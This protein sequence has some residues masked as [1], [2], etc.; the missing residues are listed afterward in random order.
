MDMYPNFYMLYAYLTEC[1]TYEHVRHKP[2]TGRGRTFVA[3][4][5]RV[6]FLIT[7]RMQRFLNQICWAPRTL[8][9][10]SKYIDGNLCLS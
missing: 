7:P 3:Y 10:E 6:Y 1:R 8:E 9:L 5:K 2:K 4:K